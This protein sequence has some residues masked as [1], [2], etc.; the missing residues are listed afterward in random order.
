MTLGDRDTTLGVCA[1]AV[2]LLLIPA[3][4]VVPGLRSAG[5]VANVIGWGLLLWWAGSRL[6]ER[7]PPQP[8][9]AAYGLFVLAVLV[10]YAAGMLSPL[11]PDQVSV[12]DRG[13]LLVLAG[14]GVVLSISDGIDHTRQLRRIVMTLVGAAG[15][16]SAIAILQFTTPIDP[17]AWIRIPGL[18]ALTG[19]TSGTDERLGFARVSATAT[20]PIEMGVVLAS[21]VPLGLHLAFRERARWAYVPVA[22][23]L[24]AIPTALSRSALIALAVAL[25]VGAVAWTWRQRV[26]V[27]AGVALAGVA[28]ELARPGL[29]GSITELFT[30]ITADSSTTGRTADYSV[31]GDYIARSP[32]I[33]S[34][35]G[36][37]VPG[38]F[39]ILD[40]QYLL[41]VVDMGLLG[42]IALLGLI[43]TGLVLAWISRRRFRDQPDRDLAVSVT[44]SLA[45]LVVSLAFFDAFSFGMATGLLWILLGISGALWRISGEL[46]Q[47]VRVSPAA[48]RI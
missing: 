47:R 9:L 46:G 10:S 26:T 7:R 40:N 29:V 34:G 16:M 43:G 38:R 45:A 36:T 15:V 28:V 41:T 27:I 3:W 44:A 42:L 12:A 14:A 25:V 37:F 17:A 24:L 31:I 20:H 2:A 30:G 19:G 18:N 33:G 39:P 6:T 1:Y 8:M 22:L 5:A 48:V 32:L 11:L 21:I 23:M 4:L 35:M 13:L